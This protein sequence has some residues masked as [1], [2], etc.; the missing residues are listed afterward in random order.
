MQSSS[1]SSARNDMEELVKIIEVP[2]DLEILNDIA[3]KQSMLHYII[4]F[5]KY[6]EIL[7]L[8]LN[9]NNTIDQQVVRKKVKDLAKQYLFENAPQ[10]I[11][12]SVE[13]IQ[14]LQENVRACG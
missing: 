5:Q 7:D 11:P 9:V 2:N 1:K 12:I 13:N 14:G 4:F 8:A 6:K 3:D 10:K